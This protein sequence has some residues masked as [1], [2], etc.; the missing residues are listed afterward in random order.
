M[1]WPNRP[2]HPAGNS[3]PPC[4][5]FVRADN[6]KD[7]SR[8]VSMLTVSSTTPFGAEE[9]IVLTLKRFSLYYEKDSQHYEKFSLHYE[10]FSQYY[11]KD[12]KTKYLID[13]LT[14]NAWQEQE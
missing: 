8:R 3:S 2:C 1:S 12:Y 4:P 10:K 13:F 9:P 5:C 11:E 14:P 7:V 6:G